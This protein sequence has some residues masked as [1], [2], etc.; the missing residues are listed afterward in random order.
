MSTI[1]A[2]LM[3]AHAQ[4]TGKSTTPQLDAEVLLA[5]T[6]NQSRAWLRAH[7]EDE[8]SVAEQA[9]FAV[10]IQR[11]CQ[12]EPVAYIT[13]H[14]EFWSL[15]LLVT[16]S[17]LVPRPETEL[18]VET[19]LSLFP[20]K[21]QCL[22][23]VDLGTG[24]GAIALALASE[25]PRWE[26]IASDVSESALSIAG[27]NAQRLGLISVSFYLSDWF[28]TLPPNQ[29]DLVVANPPYISEDEWPQFAMGLALEPHSALVAGEGG[30]SAILT[31]AKGASSRLSS[32]GILLLEHGYRQG[33]AVRAALAAQGYE[34][35]RTIKDLAG[36]E[37]VTYGQKK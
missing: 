6:L 17:T 12:G 11:R 32:S 5:E 23:V 26:I 15:D 37:R 29:F 33:M 24:S 14:Q 1:A 10:N 9:A 36:L 2:Q 18:L 28:T 19:A 21:E 30:M 7:A 13:G 22:R 35:I 20:D 16:P 3:E 4:L 34:N 27:N 25:R 31:I 8:M